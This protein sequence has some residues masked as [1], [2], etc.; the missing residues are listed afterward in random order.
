[1]NRMLDDTDQAGIVETIVAL[2]KTLGMDVTA[3]G[4]ETPEQLARLKSMK[5]AK[6]Q[7]YLFS[8]PVDTASTTAMLLGCA[9]AAAAVGEG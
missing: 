9:R 4:I 6:G 3:E 7:G 8:R 5:C 1:M 2:G